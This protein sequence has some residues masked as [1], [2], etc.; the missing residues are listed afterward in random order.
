MSRN[1]KAKW[2]ILPVAQYATARTAAM[3]SRVGMVIVTSVVGAMII[4]AISALVCSGRDEQ[5]MYQ[6][7]RRLKVGTERS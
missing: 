7:L 3:P 6:V 4:L 5:F 2:K 1:L